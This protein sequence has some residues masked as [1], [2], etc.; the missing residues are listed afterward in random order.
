M[1]VLEQVTMTDFEQGRRQ[2]QTVVLPCGSL[3]EYGSHLP[4]VLLSNWRTGLNP[5]ELN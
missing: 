2:C 4:V 1:P 3:E 5:H